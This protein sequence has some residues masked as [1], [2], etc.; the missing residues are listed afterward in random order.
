MFIK[1]SAKYRFR[2]TLILI[3]NYIFF[4]NYKRFLHKQIVNL[5]I[6]FQH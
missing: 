3:F 2:W 4:F 5:E 6:I 1:I